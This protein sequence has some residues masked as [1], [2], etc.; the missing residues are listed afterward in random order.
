M[1]VHCANAQ[2]VA[3]FLAEHPKVAE[4]T[5]PSLS[6]GADLDRAKRYLGARFGPVLQCELA[7]GRDAGGRFIESLRLVSHVT[8]IGDVRTMA[9]HPASTTHAQLPEAD[10]L[11]AGVT[12]GSVRLAVGLEHSDDLIADIGQALDD[13]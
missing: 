8:N 11:A 7:G 1:G 3:E 12:P 9:T 13:A 6:D 4:V 5:Y 2:R 10:Q